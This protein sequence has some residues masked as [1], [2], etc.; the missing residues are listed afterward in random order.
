M[1]RFTIFIL[2]A[3][4][5]WTDTIA[6]SVWELVIADNDI[7][8]YTRNNSDSNIKE[9]KIHARIESSMN[10]LVSALEDVSAH[11]EWVPFT[12]ESKILKKISESDLYYYV[13][14]DFPF[15]AKDRDVV[16]HY[17][18][19]QDEQSGIVTTNS[20]AVPELIAPLEDFIR[21]PLFNSQY[22]LQPYTDGV[23]E[24]LYTVQTNPGGNLPVWIVNFGITRGPIKTMNALKHLIASGKYADTYAVGIKEYSDRT[25]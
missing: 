11:A 13:S 1:L 6:Q 2:Y 7:E 17:L 18:R 25:Y 10:E 23:I 5:I 9:V 24:V 16:I 22:I 8:V 4:F 14:S 15:P 21:V 3:C 19:E 20:T 12:L